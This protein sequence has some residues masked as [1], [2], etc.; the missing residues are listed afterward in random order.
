MKHGSR[1]DGVVPLYNQ[2]LKLSQ[3]Q[4]EQGAKYTLPAWEAFPI[5]YLGES[6]GSRTGIYPWCLPPSF[7]YSL[8]SPRHLGASTLALG[9]HN[10]LLLPEPSLQR[11]PGSKINSFT[12]SNMYFLIGMVSNFNSVITPKNGH[13]KKSDY[14]QRQQGMTLI[15]RIRN[16]TFLSLTTFSAFISRVWAVLEKCLWSMMMAITQIDFVSR[17]LCSSL[18]STPREHQ[19]GGICF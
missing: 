7:F 18:N 5:C 2:T 16:V 17:A 1:M 13:G 12:A 8:M 6:V 19:Q 14:S 3:G 10:H 9:A 15:Q 4:M 11:S